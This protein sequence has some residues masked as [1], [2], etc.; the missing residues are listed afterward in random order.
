MEI[1]DL[2]RNKTY[3]LDEFLLCIKEEERAELYEGT[4]IF[5]AP[6]SFQHE[7]VIANLMIE[8]GNALKGK[9][10]YVFGSNMLVV[11]PFKNE[12]KKRMM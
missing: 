12:K 7:N 1:P 8:I 4:P 3:T 5:M 2:D 9:S 6:A 11:F 10:C